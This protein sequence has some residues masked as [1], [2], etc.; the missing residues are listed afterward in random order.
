MK[1]AHVILLL[2]PCL[3][4]TASRLSRTICLQE[5]DCVSAD[6]TGPELVIR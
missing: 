4:L 1:T 5:Q 3:L 2:T 6:I